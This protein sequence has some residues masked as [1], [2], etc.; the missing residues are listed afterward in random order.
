M[1]RNLSR[2]PAVPSRTQATPLINN[3]RSIP[4]SAMTTI[5]K[6]RNYATQK[7]RMDREGYTDPI[8]WKSLERQKDIIKP[9]L[10]AYLDILPRQR[11][12]TA[13]YFTGKA[14][15]T[16]LYV[17]LDRMIR[18]YERCIVPSKN[19]NQTSN[20]A[21]AAV[22]SAPKKPKNSSWFGYGA[23]KMMISENITE[24]EYQALIEKLEL[25]RK[26][27]PPTMA[28]QEEINWYLDQFRSGNAHARLVESIEEAENPEEA[29]KKK[30]QHAGDKTEPKKKRNPRRGFKDD[31]GRYFAVGHRKESSA[32]VWMVPVPGFEAK[33][34]E[35]TRASSSNSDSAASEDVAAGA[36][37]KEAVSEAH[38]QPEE[39]MATIVDEPSSIIGEV[40]VNSK[41]LGEY[42]V[43][44]YDRESTLFPLTLTEQL[45]N[46]RVWATVRGGG[47]TGQCEAVAL[48]I[49][50][51]L[52]VADPSTMETLRRSGCLTRDP[53]TVERKKT[54]Q[55]KAR[56][57]YT[58]VKR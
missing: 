42:F 44:A 15:L 26:I 48:A 49:S 21:A 25:C 6:C 40:M 52:S 11:P 43:R 54:G 34:K 28:D 36:E 41:P 2:L 18:R 23:V 3:R 13:S 8:D 33:P 46:Y 32:Q 19:N 31:L 24:V 5:P 38:V 53:R 16:D 27:K 45:G 58:W 57:R 17:A 30:A 37:E 47:P 35:T 51:A 12:D 9:D 55:P 20:D 39:E 22:D 14:K 1:L 50:R 7:Y 29:R 56:K 4:I 10:P